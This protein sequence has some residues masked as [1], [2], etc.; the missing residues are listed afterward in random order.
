[1]KS[2]QQSTNRLLSQGLLTIKEEVD[3]RPTTRRKSQPGPSSGSEAP[4]SQGLLMIKEENDD[5]DERPTTSREAEPVPSPEELR[6][7]LK[8]KETHFKLACEAARQADE[9]TKMAEQALKDS[10]RDDVKRA[11]ALNKKIDDLSNELSQY[12]RGGMQLMQQLHLQQQPQGG[13]EEQLQADLCAIL[14]AVQV[15][16][17]KSEEYREAANQAEKHR[18]I[19]DDWRI[20]YHDCQYHLMASAQKCEELKEKCERAE[21]E[22]RAHQALLVHAT[23]LKPSASLHTTHSRTPSDRREHETREEQTN[24]RSKISEKKESGEKMR[25]VPIQAPIN[26]KK[27]KNGQRTGKEPIQAQINDKKEKSGEKP[28]NEPIH[29]PI[30]EKNEK[31]IEKARNEA[32]RRVTIDSPQAQLLTSEEETDEGKGRGEKGGRSEE[33]WSI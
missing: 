19:A 28:G 32:Y 25:E 14:S 17:A 27:E 29:K 26:E 7:L 2:S 10:K 13:K 1:M 20:K 6:R 11:E 21:R 18:K 15:L 3:E 22:S 24:E 33:E 8:Q 23:P 12:K 5:V 4:L 9:R 30:N 31:S 16:Q